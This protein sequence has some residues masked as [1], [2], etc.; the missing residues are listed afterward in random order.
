MLLT[1]RALR[2][3]LPVST[4]RTRG[5]VAAWKTELGRAQPAEHLVDRGEVDLEAVSGRPQVQAPDPHALRAGQL[6]GPLAVLVEV[7]DPVAESL[8]VVGSELLDVPHDESRPLEPEHHA[9]D[10]GRLPVREDVALREGPALDVAVLQPRDAVVEQAAAGAQHGG[11]LLGVGVDLR[12]ADVLDHPDRGD[13]V[14]LLAGQLA[15]VLDADL[16]P[17][18]E[19]RIGHALA[20]QHGLR[21]GE[22]DPDGLYAVARGRVHHEAAPTATHVE[23]ALALL[24]RELGADEIELGLLGLLE[25]GGAA[26]ED[27]AR[28]GHRAIEEE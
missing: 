12:L 1:T 5:T 17:V 23:D 2:T 11:E 4:G 20:R 28:V 10:V 24:E 13:R 9:R 26:G 19:S 3:S 27:R 21:L 8:R 22:S 18:R 15:V 16:D 25:R 14:E 7:A 6:L